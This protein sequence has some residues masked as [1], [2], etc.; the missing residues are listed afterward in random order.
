VSFLT[1]L[2]SKKQPVHVLV[3]HGSVHIR[4]PPPVDYQQ[5]CS[6]FQDSQEGRVEGIVWHC[7]D[8]TLVKVSALEPIRGSYYAIK[9]RLGLWYVFRFSLLVFFHHIIMKL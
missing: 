2:G 8:G 5:L 4:N 3:A 9:L 1:G 7:N 6:W